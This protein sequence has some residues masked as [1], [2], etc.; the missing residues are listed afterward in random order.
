MG[1]VLEDLI[2]RGIKTTDFFGGDIET[3]KDERIKIYFLGNKPSLHESQNPE[4][5]FLAVPR[6]YTLTE[7]RPPENIIKFSISQNKFSAD[8]FNEGMAEEVRT[9]KAYVLLTNL[10]YGKEQYVLPFQTEDSFRYKIFLK[11]MESRL[12]KIYENY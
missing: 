3:Y 4:L 5:H 7:F 10:N 8:Y 1:V 2:N 11:N 6:D 12:L 9:K